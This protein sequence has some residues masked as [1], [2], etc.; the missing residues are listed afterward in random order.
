VFGR[1]D[2]FYKRSECPG[3]ASKCRVGSDQNR[4]RKELMAVLI[5]ALVLT[6][7]TGAHYFG[8]NL[9]IPVWLVLFIL[10]ALGLLPEL[11]AYRPLGI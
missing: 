5:L 7:I 2:Y 8:R 11:I 4:I 3:I 6:I 9:T 1:Y 10:S